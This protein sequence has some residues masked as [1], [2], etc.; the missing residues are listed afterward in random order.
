MRHLQPATIGPL[1]VDA[2]A[3]EQKQ[4]EI[5]FAR[6][7]ALPLLA[8]ECLFQPLERG[9]QSQRTG[10]G[11]GTCRD[12]ERD[13]GVQKV[14]LRDPTHR[15]RSVEPG[16][17]A[18]VG[19]R[20]SIKGTNGALERGARVAHV[21][22]EPDV[23]AYSL[24]QPRLG[25]GMTTVTV[26]IFHRPANAGEPELVQ[27]LASVRDQ[28]A[29]RHAE[30][31]RSA[32]ATE[33]RFVDEWHNDLSFGKV[34]AQLAPA[35]GGAVVLSGGAVPLLNLR[36]ARRLVEV[37]RADRP[38][39]MTNNRYSSDVCAIAKADTL[40]RLPPLPT[41][42]SL[43]RWLE[44]RAGYSVTELG[45]RER[46]GL[47]LDT[48]QDIALAALA[49][50]SQSWLRDAA[51]ASHLAVPRR[52]DLRELAGDPHA[53]ML[54]F[55]RSGASTLRWL[56]KNV[57]CRVRFLAEERGL[58]ASTPLAIGGPVQ[59][60][61]RQQRPRATLG[62][63]LDQ[64]GPESLAQIVAKLGRGAII[65]SRVLLAHRLGADESRWPSPA[66]RFASDLHRATEIG[67]PWLRAL[68]ESAAGS[69]LP[70]LLGGHSLVGPGI[71]LLL[72]KRL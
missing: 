34:L 56:E 29:A 17:S 24:A 9:E 69:Q 20:Q 60:E 52:D 11:I 25:G 28:L 54:V 68:T 57:R 31:F 1:D 14:R 7:P 42:N 27:V 35:L 55:G 46:L 70:I 8:P 59:A 45:G 15:A 32:G 47:D 33:V 71:R 40:R 53:E 3:A 23:G 67:D 48:P 19:T 43:P 18:D 38:T 36:D 65:D 51:R 4:V 63:L 22:A 41:D 50:G 30:L 37:A 2:V 44:E 62:L 66:D 26:L 64:R 12:I 16:N 10:L 21:R 61:V 58:R 49:R 6:S 39:A 5:Q 72:N 13:H